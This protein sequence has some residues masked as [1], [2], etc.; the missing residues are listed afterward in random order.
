MA[1][2]HKVVHVYGTDGN[3]SWMW[4]FPDGVWNSCFA[5]EGVALCELS[6]ATSL[7]LEWRVPGGTA[8]KWSVAN[9][10]SLNIS[11]L[12]AGVE[13][14]IWRKNSL[15]GCPSSSLWG[16]KLDLSAA[17]GWTYRQCH[18][19]FSSGG[20]IHSNMGTTQPQCI[21]P[22]SGWAGK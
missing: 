5:L 7:S 3:T 4:E 12:L 8:M 10:T 9:H 20:S 14:R 16:T 17:R 18:W 13:S 6:W 11:T 2:S 22:R 21:D 15:G 1:L 19:C